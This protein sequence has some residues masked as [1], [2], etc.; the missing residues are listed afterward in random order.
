MKSGEKKRKKMKETSAGPQRMVVL[1]GVEF[2][3]PDVNYLTCFN[4]GILQ[5]YI[6]GEELT[7]DVE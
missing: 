1:W 7:T 4:I 3:L 2:E 5:N 6:P